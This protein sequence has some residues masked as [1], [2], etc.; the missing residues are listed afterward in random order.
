MKNHVYFLIFNGFADWEAALA[1]CAIREQP[2]FKI[3]TV[4]F[5]KDPITSMGGLK[6]IPDITLNELNIEDALIFIL[7]GGQLW[8]KFSDSQ[9]TTLLHKLDSAG[10]II[11]AICAATLPLAQAGL[12]QDRLHTS[13]SKEFLKEFVPDYAGETFYQDKLA[14]TGS[15]LITASGIGSVDFA[16]EIMTA[17]SIYDESTTLAWLE[18]FKHGLKPKTVSS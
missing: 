4:G 10:V 8:E 9:F 5:S 6:V 12:L 16:Y 7:P 18:L 11:A 13:N 1:L 14:I 17:L 3:M 15:N 2:S